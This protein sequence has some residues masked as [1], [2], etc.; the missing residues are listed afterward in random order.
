LSPPQC[1]LFRLQLEF[2]LNNNK[3]NTIFSLVLYSL[4]AQLNNFAT[5][6][7]FVCVRVSENIL[8]SFE[9]FSFMNNN[10][11][12]NI[13]FPKISIHKFSVVYFLH[14]FETKFHFLFNFNNTLIFLH[15][16]THTSLCRVIN[17]HE[18]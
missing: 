18:G 2:F 1:Y 6:Y 9:S 4:L 10:N 16:L 3:K 11:N 17:Y 7:L 14:G 5:C 8:F 15:T 12:K 13:Y